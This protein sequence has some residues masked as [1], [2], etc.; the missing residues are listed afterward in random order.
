MNRGSTDLRFCPSVKTVVITGTGCDIWRAY[1][2]RER[3]YDTLFP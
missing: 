3:M 2:Q 1:E